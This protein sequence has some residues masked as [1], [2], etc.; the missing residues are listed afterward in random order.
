MRRKPKSNPIY[1]DKKF[2]YSIYRSLDLNQNE[3]RRPY[4]QST[5]LDFQKSTNGGFEAMEMNRR[6]LALHF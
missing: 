3:C 1:I 5:I 6:G 4:G 2:Y